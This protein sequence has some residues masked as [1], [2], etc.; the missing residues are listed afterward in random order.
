VTVDAARHAFAGRLQY[1]RRRRQTDA[2]LPCGNRQR[3][4]NH[5]RRRLCERRREAQHVGGGDLRAAFDRDD[6]CAPAGQR[7]G[8][9]EEQNRRLR[10]AFQRAA[11]LD[12]HAALRAARHARHDRDRHRE[13]QRTRRRDD[14]HRERAADV[15]GREPR[16]ARDEQ[17]NHDEARRVAIRDAHGRAALALRA[18]DHPY[19]AGKRAVAGGRARHH[20]E[21]RAGV[22]HAAACGFAR[23]S[24]LRGRFAGQHRFVQFRVAGECAVD[25]DALAAAHQQPVAEDDRTRSDGPPFAMLE[26]RRPPRRA[27]EQRGH[28]AL[29]AALRVLLQRPPAREHQCDD[30]GGQRL[31]EREREPDREPREHVDAGLPARDRLGDGDRQREQHGQRAEQPHEARERRQAERDAR[32]AGGER[33]GR[34]NQQREIERPAHSGHDEFSCCRAWAERCVGRR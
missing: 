2:A 15:A 1:G 18:L 32:A 7:A 34:Q 12:Q 3:V 24:P 8:L 29:R 5:V 27:A 22:D 33:D 21:R 11:A 25:R 30:R 19:D 23:T 16:A 26:P 28:L 4:R 20:F 14:E 31:V 13:N 9:V 17:R 6:A 10:E